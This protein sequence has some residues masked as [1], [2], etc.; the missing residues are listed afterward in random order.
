MCNRQQTQKNPLK[1]KQG[2]SVSLQYYIPK[3][4]ISSTSVAFF[5]VQVLCF[6]Y[7]SEDVIHSLLLLPFTNTAVRQDLSLSETLHG[8]VVIN[9]TN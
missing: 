2:P 4:I 8:N 7:C 6:P 9:G 5:N 1:E 3:P